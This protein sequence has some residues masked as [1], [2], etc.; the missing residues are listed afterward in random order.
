MQSTDIGEGF[1]ICN[2]L[3]FVIVKCPSADVGKGFT[4]GNQLILAR[5]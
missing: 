2:Q 3:G 1:V 4:I 5:V